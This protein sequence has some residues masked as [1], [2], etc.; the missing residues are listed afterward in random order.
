MTAATVK[1][2]VKYFPLRQGIN[3][4]PEVRKMFPETHENSEKLTD[5]MT[6]AQSLKNQGKIVGKE[7]ESD[8]EHYRLVSGAYE[9]R[10]LGQICCIDDHHSGTQ[11]AI[12]SDSKHKQVIVRIIVVRS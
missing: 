7:T 6:I 10:H 9:N 2:S 3:T 8:H 1:A 12:W 11:A 4:H 5:W